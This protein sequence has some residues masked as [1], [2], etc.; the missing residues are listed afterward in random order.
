[1]NT[2]T[3]QDWQPQRYDRFAIQRQRAARDLLA[4]V[5]E[6]DAR[7]IEDLGCGSGLSTALLLERWPQALA[8]GIDNSAA[9][10]RA[11]RERVPGATFV[12]DTIANR[13]AG[14]CVDLLFAN[15][16]LHWVG[17]H[18]RLLPGLLRRLNPGGVLA[19][20]MP[21][22]SDE[23][24]HSLME[25]V[26]ARP[27][28]APYRP[29]SSEVRQRLESIDAYFDC[30]ATQDCELRI[31]ETRYLHELDDAAAIAAWFAST[32]LRPYL[33]ALPAPLRDVFLEDYICAVS[34]YY[35]PRAN[36]NVLL[37]MPRLFIV[38]LRRG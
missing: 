37:A 31:W 1:M 2:H 38:A 33:E 30:L 4:A 14:D 8:T 35:R 22:N 16:S 10:L 29:H 28:Y 20:Q 13:L 17:D 36:G 6:L 34:A 5:P 32:A 19:L 9:M 11:A 23:P 18:L 24:S 7:Q 12:Q 26:A 25:E 27:A 3:P 15:A 21:N